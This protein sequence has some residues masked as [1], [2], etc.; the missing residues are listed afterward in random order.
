MVR[1]SLLALPLLSCGYALVGLSSNLPADI[2]D[3]FISPLENA[4][5]RAQV[6]QFLTDAIT[7]EMLARRRYNIVNSSRE[8]DAQLLGEITSFRVTPITFDNEGRATEYEIS[9][10]AD[11][12]F[13]RV[14]S[15]EVIWENENYLFREIYEIDE[16][17]N[18]FFDQENIAALEAS[19]RFAETIITDILEGF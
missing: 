10:S 9:I 6:E 11:V 16:D 13:E 12:S 2:E 17:E 4:T 3:I 8:A 14:E 5:A 7:E 19:G 1:V 15:E 18:T